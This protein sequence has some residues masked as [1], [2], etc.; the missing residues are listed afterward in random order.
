MKIVKIK[1]KHGQTLYAVKK[2]RWFKFLRPLYYNLVRYKG[3][4]PKTYPIEHELFVPCCL[5]M[6]IE[7]CIL[8][9]ENQGDPM[10]NEEEVSPVELEILYGNKNNP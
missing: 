4:D 9:M 7:V 3:K 8:F 2:A 10:A 1:D 6:Y 5:T